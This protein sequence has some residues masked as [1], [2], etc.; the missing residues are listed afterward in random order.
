[1]LQILLLGSLFMPGQT[2]KETETTDKKV[3]ATE[4]TGKDTISQWN[5]FEK[6]DFVVAGRKALLVLP[7]REARVR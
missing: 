1:M 6:R 2:G 3:A 4:G 7:A 5:G